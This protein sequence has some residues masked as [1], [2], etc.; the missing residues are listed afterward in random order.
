MNQLIL[1]IGLDDNDKALVIGC[2]KRG[3]V[4]YEV[5]CPILV[6]ILDLKCV[7][8]DVEALLTKLECPLIDEVLVL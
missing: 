7:E 8:Q 6:D 1:R 4:G 3:Q 2:D 5:Q